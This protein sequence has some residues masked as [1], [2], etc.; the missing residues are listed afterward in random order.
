MN[1]VAELEEKCNKQSDGMGARLA[2]M[3]EDIRVIEE[4]LQAVGDRCRYWG[5]RG[6]WMEGWLSY[7]SNLTDVHSRVIILVASVSTRKCN[8]ISD[9]TVPTS[10][11]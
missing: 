5:G 4:G 2:K 9:P 8:N 11:R 10:T 1:E 6:Q 7:S 3:N